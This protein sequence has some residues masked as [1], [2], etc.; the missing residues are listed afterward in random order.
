[1]SAIADQLRRAVAPPPIC[2]NV[3]NGEEV[4]GA[5]RIPVRDPARD[6]QISE[7]AEADAD[8]VDQAVRAATAA[9]ERGDWRNMPVEAR[10]DIL[11]RI[12]ALVERE[13]DRLAGLECLNTGIPRAHLLAG[14][15]RRV[16]LNFRFFADYIGQAGGDVYT[17]NTD[18]LTYVRR[19]PVGVSALIGPW[20]APLALATMKIAGAI[21]FGNSCVV[22]PSEQ[23]PL[24]A[25]ALMPLLAEAG[26]PA[27]VVN[28][29]N[30]RGAVTG[31]ALSSH[32][33][34]DRIS[35]TGGGVA[36]RE[37]MRAASANLTPVTMELGGKSANIIFQSADFERALDGALIGIFSNNGQQCLAGSRILIEE[38]IAK[39]FIDALTARAER[40]LI[41]DPFDSSTE[42]GALGSR[43]HRERVL[44]Y[45]SVGAAE[46]ASLLTGGKRVEALEPGAYMAPTLMRAN[47]NR[48]RI[49]QEEIFGPFGVVQTFRTAE[50]AFRI[51][52][53]SKF[54]LVSYVWSDDAPT[55]MAAQ[56]AL[57]S[58]LVWINTP[59]VRELRAPFGGFRESGV[60]REGGKACEAFYTEEKTVTIAVR[61]SPLPQFGRSQ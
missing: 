39:R 14:Q 44:S 7:I 43:A 52:N 50:E 59:M 19:E 24:T 57:R 32:P 56:S 3:I 11:R 1:M 29:V 20:N 49:C 23:T 40:I 60:G 47:D 61:K 21:A 35:F 22:K 13:Q 54:G 51:A 30:G 4:S 46:G 10:Q 17:Q 18:Y 48:G 31:A 27:G 6:A 37:I 2:F 15:I 9:F 26:L 58:G 41:G 42:I 28:L 12:A 8:V 36:G 5:F 45:V 34:V 53:D 38:A 55:I 16:A 33:L 25:A